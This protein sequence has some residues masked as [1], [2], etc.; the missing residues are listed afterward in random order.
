M[1][2]WIELETASANSSSTSKSGRAPRERT[3][4]L[5]K[6]LM[7]RRSRL[8]SCMTSPF[9]RRS[10][11][12]PDVCFVPALAAGLSLALTQ[13]ARP[14]SGISRVT[15]PYSAAMS[16]L[17][18]CSLSPLGDA[19]I[20]SMRAEY[21]A[22]FSRPLGSSVRCARLYPSARGKRDVNSPRRNWVVDSL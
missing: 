4:L 11:A 13:G 1:V 22:W 3:S 18:R 14:W 16:W 20:G 8:G 9:N 5:I 6:S 7:R 19:R 10:L 15:F 2:V 12:S 21:S 17:W